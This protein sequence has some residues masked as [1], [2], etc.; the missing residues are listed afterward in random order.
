MENL[1]L[2]E[3]VLGVLGY[4]LAHD[5]GPSLDDAVLVVGGLNAIDA[6]EHL[7]EFAY[8]F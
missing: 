2:D 4:N 8:L 7:D 5:D 1:V 6:H 3:N